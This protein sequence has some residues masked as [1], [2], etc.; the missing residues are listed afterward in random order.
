VAYGRC[1]EWQEGGGYITGIVDAK[2]QFSGDETAFVYP[3]FETTL[4]GRSEN[5]VMI[6]ARPAMLECVDIINDIA[7]PVFTISDAPTVA[8][9]RSSRESVGKDPLVRDPYEAST[10]QVRSSQVDGGGEGLYANRDI[11]KGDIV[12][13]YNGI[14]LPPAC[15]PKEDWDSSG[16]KIFANTNEQWG[17]RIDLPGDLIY[18]ENYCATLGHKVNHSFVY[19]CTEWFFKHPRHDLIPCTKAIRDIQEGEEL[20]LHYG[21][22]PRNC[23]SWY[24]PAIDAFILD[25]PELELMEAANPERQEKAETPSYKEILLKRNL[26][27]L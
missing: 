23:P 18:L 5:G 8:H 15:G 2:G 9:C 12:A 3:D 27:E 21:Y 25:N 11:K 17:E 24:G 6:S 22:D 10:V 20:F 14:R 19:N 4:F 1:W 13:F 7:E 26:M 16:Y